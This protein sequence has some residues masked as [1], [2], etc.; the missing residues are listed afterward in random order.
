M[1]KIKG[2]DLVVM[3]HDGESWKAVAFATDCELDINITMQEKGQEVSGRWKELEPK[4]ISWKVTSSHLLSDVSQPVDFSQLIADGT[5]MKICFS[6]VAPH[7]NPKN[8]PPEYEP[9]YSLFPQPGYV[10]TRTGDVYVARH[11]V[12]SRNRA[13]VT[14]FVEMIGTGKLIE[15]SINLHDF[16]PLSAPDFGPTLYPDF[17]V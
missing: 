14:S 16:G 7:L 10:Y 17:N 13:Y 8:D 2:Q 6:C 9:Y 15:G 1:A 11:T 4:E 12:S 5:K 3:F